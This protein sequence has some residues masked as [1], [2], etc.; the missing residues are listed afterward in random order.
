MTT[1][2]QEPSCCFNPFVTALILYSKFV[3]NIMFGDYK[4]DD[5]NFGDASV[6]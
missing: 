6:I 5:F 4:R 3:G 1:Q 2:T